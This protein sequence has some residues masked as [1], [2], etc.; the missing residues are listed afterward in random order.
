MYVRTKTPE[1]KWFYA[2]K[3]KRK[4][5][6]CSVFSQHSQQL[7]LH[8]ASTLLVCLQKGAGGEKC[9]LEEGIERAEIAEKL[10][11]KTECIESTTGTTC[12]VNIPACFL[13]FAGEE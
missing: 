12:L 3:G 6:V 8:P 10:G 4:G 13:P 11:Y 1:R 5:E 2:D 7:L 9:L